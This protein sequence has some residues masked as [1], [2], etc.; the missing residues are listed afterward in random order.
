MTA[1]WKV[2]HR[3]WHQWHVE[4]TLEAFRAA[5]DSGCDMV[6]FD[7][8]LSRDGVPVVFHDDDCKRLA[9]RRENVFD[10]DW[11]ELRA[12][13]M[14][15]PG[16]PG[17]RGAAYKI[18]SLEQFLAEFGSRAFYLELKVPKAVAANRGYV[19]ML[20]EK[21]AQMAAAGPHPDTFLGSFHGGILRHVHQ[22][23]LFPSLAG[24]FEDYERFEAV[25]SGK[26]AET[27]V[28]IRHF[29]V[30]WDIFRRFARES[31]AASERAA[32][33][34]R[35]KPS[36]LDLL[37]RETTGVP[38]AELFLIWDLQGEKELRA[39]QGYGVRGLVADDV[40]ALVRI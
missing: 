22:G 14:P 30:S 1:C 5:Y 2:A 11:K 12:L 26:D 33:H 38:G 36:E 34:A 15:G 40:E 32:R 18:P 37:S 28:A 6:E 24:I 8:Q 39:A 29:S 3:G 21:C 17:G 10:L 19:E 25:H 4:N 13:S 9:G 20:G 35:V 31:Q 23:N 16:K 27:A 7:V